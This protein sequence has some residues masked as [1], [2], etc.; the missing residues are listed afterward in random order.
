M[1]KLRI[2]SKCAK[3]LDDGRRLVLEIID[4]ELLTGG[5]PVV[6]VTMLRHLDGRIDGIDTVFDQLVKWTS[7]EGW[8][9]IEDKF[10]TIEGLEFPI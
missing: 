2:G 10:V 1:M 7:D 5:Y 3:T 9:V 8:E 4:I 6:S